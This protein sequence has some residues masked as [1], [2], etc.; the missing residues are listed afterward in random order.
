MVPDSPLAASPFAIPKAPTGIPG[1]DDITHGGIP[2]GR[3]TLV[4]GGPG[5]GKTVLGMEFLV[6]GAV[7]YGEPGLFVSFSETTDNLLADFHSLGIDIESLL[8]GNLLRISQVLLSPEEF[9]EV[10]VFSL[11]GLLIRLDQKIGEIGAKRVVLDSIETVYSVLSNSGVLRN[12]IARLIYWLK[13]KGVTAIVTGERG[14]ENLTRHGFD[15]YASDCVILLDHRVTEQISKRRV[16]VVKYRGSGH[17]ADEY[18]FIIGAS[19]VSVLPVTSVDLDYEASSDRITSGVPD[20]DVMLDGKGYLRGSSIMVSGKAGTG[21]TTLAAA[22][23]IASCERGD[24]CL[25]LSFEESAA[26]VI[27]NMRSVG[28]DMD[29][30]IEKGLLTIRAARPSSRGLEEHLISIRDLIA[31]IK[32]DC[33]VFDPVTNFISVGSTEEVKSMLLRVMDSTKHKGITVLVTA[34]TPGSGS[35]DETETNVSSLV[36]TWIA[37][38]MKPVGHMRRRELYVIKARGMEHSCETHEVVL[39]SSGVT[40]VRMPVEE[41]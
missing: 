41:H 2:R 13:E 33:V 25:Y 34:L 28:M 30:W 21:K 27:R 24:R 15:E 36:D 1:L 18:P 35:T 39:A 19:G 3:T 14:T 16:R 9:V 26:Q 23:A 22:F 5:C 11:D 31:D 4:C 6:H 8:Q 37:L 29:R 20:L 7:E 12:E 40:L 10:G 38:E 32:P 17:G